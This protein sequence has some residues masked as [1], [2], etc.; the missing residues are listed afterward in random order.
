VKFGLKNQDIDLILSVLSKHPEL[1]SAVIFGS[2]AKETHSAGS[3]ID[4]ALFGDDLT[5][6]ILN[7]IATELD[8]LLLPYQFDLLLWN[9]LDHGDLK[10]HIQRVGKEFYS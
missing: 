10:N 6:T 8:D 3:D 1:K 4:L 7:T 2:R 9:Q 5:Q